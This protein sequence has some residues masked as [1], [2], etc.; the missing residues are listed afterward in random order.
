MQK[1]VCSLNFRHEYKQEIN[2]SDMLA[3]RQSLSAVMKPDEHSVDGKYLIR[4]VYFDNIYDTALL[5]KINGVNKREKFRIRLYNNDNSFIRLEKKSKINGLC[6]KESAPLTAEQAQKTV[7]GDTDWMKYSD[8]EL[9]KEFR[10]KIICR[11]LEAKT[12]V[13]YTRE[14][15]VFP[16]GNVRITLDYNIRTGFAVQDFLS[17]ECVTLPTEDSVIILE[18]KW[19]NFL[20]QVIADTVQLKNRRTCSFS[21]YASCRIYG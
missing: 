10:Q 1:G 7:C 12:I 20:P 4:S 21:K 19:D 3:L 13:D 2:L 16:A 11:G 15:F 17:S 8:D 6:S 14:A 9:I 5:E 18:V